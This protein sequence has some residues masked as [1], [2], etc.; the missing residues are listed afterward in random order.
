MIL[1]GNPDQHTRHYEAMKL[2]F[3]L[4]LRIMK[5]LIEFFWGEQMLSLLLTRDL[6]T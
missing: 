3:Q 2:V 5:A 6:S 1:D 4:L